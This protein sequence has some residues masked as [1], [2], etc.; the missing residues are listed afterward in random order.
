MNSYL[1]ITI[2]LLTEIIPFLHGISYHSKF[3]RRINKIS[4]EVEDVLSKMLVVDVNKRIEWPDLF[5]HPIVHLKE[6]KIK[7]ELHCTL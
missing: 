1:L 4:K 6:D 7:N 3:P 2:L 5:D